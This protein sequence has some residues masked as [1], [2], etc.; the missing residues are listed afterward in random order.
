MTSS[1]RSDP[2]DLRGRRI[3]VTGG[4]GFLG[5]SLLDYLRESVDRHG[6]DMRV[7][8][9]SRSPE[10]FLQTYP[11]YARLSWL[12][13]VAGDLR[14][15]PRVEARAYTDLIHGAADTHSG[16][17]PVTWLEQLVDG[18]RRMLD[19]SRD[20]GVQRLLFISS[21]AVYGPQPHDVATLREDHPFAPSTLDVRALYGHGKR[22]AEHLCAQYAAVGGPECVIARCFAIVSSHVPLDGP[23]AMGNFLRDALAGQ[24]IRISGSGRTVRSY[25]DGR[26]MAHWM[27]TLLHRGRSGEAYNVGS[28]QPV[29]TLELATAIREVVGIDQPI[30]VGD[31]DERTGRSVYLPSIDKAGDLGLRIETPLREALARTVRTLR[32]PCPDRLTPTSVP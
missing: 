3:F 11:Q 7:T 26:D 25:I 20:T 14:N 29:S 15:L 32:A 17:D 1:V 28:D 8:V 22:M 24:G 9:L 2:L 13:F 12:D 5:R 16:T 27:L 23:Y 18:T 10:R 19:L 21:G 4:T 31:P 30:E 6:A